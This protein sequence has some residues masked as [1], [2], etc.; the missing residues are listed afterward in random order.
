MDKSTGYVTANDG[1]RLYYEE[2]GSGPPVIMIHGG[3]V[4]STRWRKNVPALSE[5]F[6]VITP[7]TRGCGKSDRPEWGHNTARYA[8]DVYDIIHELD[9]DDVTL[10]GWSIGARTSYSF[11]D[12]FGGY[13]LRGVVIVDETVHIDLHEP[14]PSGRTRRPGQSDE[15]YDRQQIIDNF[16]PENAKR[17]TEEEMQWMLGS[18]TD[19]EVI[20]RTLSADYRAQD[21]R[22]LCPTIKLPVLV[23]TGRYAGAKPGCFYAAEHIPNAR[24]EMFETSGHNLHYEEADKFN[25]VVADFVVGASGPG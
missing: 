11:L 25:R 17:L 20:W 7:D 18:R 22:A 6:R 15:D 5:Q 13:R 9:L 1:V 8:K 14:P 2:A 24:L 21:W 10:V 3:G 16:G 19:H 4:D 12:L 23:T